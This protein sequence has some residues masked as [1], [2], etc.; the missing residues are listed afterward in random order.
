MPA[1]VHRLDLHIHTPW[2][3]CYDDYA[4]PEAKLKTTPAAIGAAARAA[5]L[6]GIAITDHNTA[7]GIDPLRE[8]AAGRGLVILPG[9]ELSCRGGHL[10]A[11]FPE[12]TPV[13]DL[14]LLL[15]SLG[16][17][18]AEEGEGHFSA[19]VWL[20]EAARRVAEAGGLAIAA[21]I[22]RKPK[23]FTVTEEP[24]G[25][26]ARLHACP[27]IAALEIT[28]AQNKDRWNRGQMPGYPLGRPCIQGSDAHAPDEIGRRT[29]EIKATRISLAELAAALAEHETR[30][31]FVAAAAGIRRG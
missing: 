29:I 13:A 24:L 7:A 19:P 2:S 15:R 3:R 10:L 16:F 23:G 9:M 22:D 25:I 12:E 8:A 6:E 31:S 20:D 14:R 28:Q 18:E 4:T 1:S 5:G 27:Y 17:P 30:V 11:L 26:K 21:H